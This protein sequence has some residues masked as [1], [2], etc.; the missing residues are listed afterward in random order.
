MFWVK[1]V[2]YLTIFFTLYRKEGLICSLYSQIQGRYLKIK[3]FVPVKSI[4][5]FC[6]LIYSV[7]HPEM[8][9]VLD[10]LQKEI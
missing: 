5:I 2:K 8:K 3:V 10:Y 1:V 7:F 6:M 9:M 4:M